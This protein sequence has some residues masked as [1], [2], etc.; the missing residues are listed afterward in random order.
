MPHSAA[1][2][3]SSSSGSAANT[4]AAMSVKVRASF[5]EVLALGQRGLV[6][7]EGAIDLELQG[8]HAARRI[9]VVL[10]DE[11]AGIGPVDLHLV[12][13]RPAARRA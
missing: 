11:A 6:E 9:A 8:L 7:I 3:R 5:G 2:R 12:A 4:L 10:G 13:G 1:A